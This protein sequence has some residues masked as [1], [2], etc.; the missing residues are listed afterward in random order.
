M[1]LIKKVLNSLK[2]NGFKR[3]EKIIDAT[4]EE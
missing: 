4:V 1:I 3:F 2:L